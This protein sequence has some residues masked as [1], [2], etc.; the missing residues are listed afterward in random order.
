MILD[1]KTSSEFE[2]RKTAIADFNKVRLDI[3]VLFC[4]LYL[5]IVSP[6]FYFSSISLHSLSFVSS[7][8]LFNFLSSIH[9]CIF[10]SP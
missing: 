10:V 6:F 1:L 3:L 4:I 2:K 7:F 9:L 5:Y 8:F